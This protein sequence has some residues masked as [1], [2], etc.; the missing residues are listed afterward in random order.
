MSTPDIHQALLEVV[1]ALDHLGVPYLVGGSVASSAFGMARTTLDADLVAELETSHVSELV[2]GLT[3]RF[4]VD[5]PM[6]REAI[7]HRACFNVVHLETMLKVDVFVRG[8]SPYDRESFARRV[9][10]R[11]REDETEPMIWFSTPEDT[12]LHKIL[13]YQEGHGLSDRQWWDVL[14]VLKVQAH[15]LDRAYLEHWARELDITALLSRALNEA[16]L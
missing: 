11:L 8:S 4:Y 1:R 9:E 5:E 14:G 16:G 7:K 3:A 15:G 12:V 10:D 6:V 13:W 2:S